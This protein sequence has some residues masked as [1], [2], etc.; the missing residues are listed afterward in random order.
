MQALKL[1]STKDLQHDDWLD[2]RRKGIGGSDVSAICGMNR[3]RSP[4]AVYLDKIG[5]LPPIE[6]NDAMYWGRTLEDIVAKEFSIRTN[7]RVRRENKMLQHPD[8]D[9]MLAN[10][11][12]MIVAQ[13]AGL[14]CKTA[15]EYAK[16]DWTGE[17]V[18]KEYALQCHHY[19]ACT[20]S[21]RWYV[22][23]L[24]GG[25]KFE[26]RVIERDDAI[27][28][29]LIKI[30][31]NF[32]NNHVV[33]KIPPAFGAH[34]ETLLGQMYP[35]SIPTKSVELGPDAHKIIAAVYDS[36]NRLEAA[37]YDFED[38]K[39]QIKGMMGDA[40]VAWYMTEP[41]FTWKSTSRGHRQFKIIGG[42]E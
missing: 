14:E 1:V 26:W 30:E 15:N 32:W 28:N 22:A 2:W 3:Y 20:G 36:K 38:S 29:S 12:R 18:P 9:F 34:D 35:T 24:I 13:N 23:V 10:V 40:E 41:V 6:D 42:N 16:D 19:M 4:M 39:N 31:S 11:D 37:K 7:L 25:N 5:D 27:I 33:P 8:H 17:A 21:D